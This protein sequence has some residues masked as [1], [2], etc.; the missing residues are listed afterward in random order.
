MPV[1]QYQAAVAQRE[2]LG[3]QLERLQDRRN[4]ITR[5][6]AN[7]MTRGADRSGLEARLKALDERILALDKSIE[8][9]DV[10]VTQAAGVPGAVA[11]LRAQERAQRL[12]EEA[13]GPPEELFVLGGMLIV[14]V[15]LPLSIAHARRIWRRSASAVSAPPP[16]LMDRMSRVEQGVESIAIE[17]ERIGE[18]QRFLTRLFT[19]SGQGR[20][21]GSAPAE[22]F[23]QPVRDAVPLRAEP[24]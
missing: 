10:A 12:A 14:V 24:L 6:L 16:E 21:L 17:V 3:R 9:A 7:D 15:G 18:G 4:D 13:Q 1:T 22:P 23:R 11:G 20:A 8:A 19:E 2:E 5:E